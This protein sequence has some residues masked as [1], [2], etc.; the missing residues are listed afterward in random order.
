[1]SSFWEFAGS[2]W[3]LVFPLGAVTGGWVSGIAKYNER[4]RRDKIEMLRIKHGAKAVETEARQVTEHE[5]DRALTTHDDINRRWFEYEIDVARLI[6]YPMMTDTREPLT[7][8]FHEA[9]VLADDL[10]PADRD[11]LRDPPRLAEYTKAVRAYRMAFE[12]AE[13]EAQRR[14]QSDF[15]AAERAALDRARKLITVA[16]DE[17]AT[18]AERQN[19]YRRA[20]QELDGLIVLPHV[21]TESLESRIAGALEAGP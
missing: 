8:Q 15:T 14:R 11:E 19:A 13:R 18:P 5:I 1:M 9:K 12:V 16:V 3:W 20:R 6:E 4:R 2:Y 17:A 7:V 10:R 21:A